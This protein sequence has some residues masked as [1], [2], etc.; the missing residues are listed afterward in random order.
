[1]AK[2]KVLFDYKKYGVVDELIVD[3]E[4]NQSR[5]F[6]LILSGGKVLM[7]SSNYTVEFYDNFL[8]G[9]YGEKL[10]FAIEYESIVGYYINTVCQYGDV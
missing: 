8:K 5:N 2:A 4:K 10:A 7:I 1:M 9:Y 6:S 3:L